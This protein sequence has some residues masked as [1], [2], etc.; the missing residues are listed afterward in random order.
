MEKRIKQ[1]IERVKDY[2][3]EGAFQQLYQQYYQKAYYIALRMTNNDADAQDAVQEA[4]IQIQ[5]SIHELKE[6]EK[7]GAWLNTIVLSKCK[8]IFRKN[9]YM[10]ADPLQMEKYPN[11]IE[12]RDY[13][14]PDKGHKKRV[15]QEILLSMI[16]QLPVIQKEVVLLA[17]FE[18]Y[19]YRE[20]AEILGITENTV[21]SRVLAAKK[22]LR[23]AIEAYEKQT[24]HKLTFRSLDFAITSSLF[25]GYGIEAF[26]GIAVLSQGFRHLLQFV[27]LHTLETA[28]AG[29]VCISSGVAIVGGYHNYID[30]KKQGDYTPLQSTILETQTN[31]T[32][33]HAFQPIQY[34]TRTITTS[35]EAYFILVLWGNTEEQIK[36]KTKEECQSVQELYEALK[37][38]NSPY[39]H[40]LITK[41]WTTLYENQLNFTH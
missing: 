31:K 30:S 1:M 38:S 23:K 41:G 17:Y 22:S 27:K 28:V 8:R 10:S 5:K 25:A 32:E 15:D 36:G 18:Q 9:H 7:F 40:H 29:V 14:L 16:D 33:L 13:M 20:I 26:S 21:K 11:Q 3:D 12:Q 24:D 39:Y 35:E 6:P 2:H 37:Q 19:K 4:F 34:E